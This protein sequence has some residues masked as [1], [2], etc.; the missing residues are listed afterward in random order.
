MASS[1]TTIATTTDSVLTAAEFVTALGRSMIKVANNDGQ[2]GKMTK[3]RLVANLSRLLNEL[4]G[5]INHFEDIQG[6]CHMQGAFTPALYNGGWFLYDAGTL[7]RYCCNDADEPAVTPDVA[8]ASTAVDADVERMAKLLL[9]DVL[10]VV[11]TAAAMAVAATGWADHPEDYRALRIRLQSINSLARILS[12]CLEHADDAESNWYLALLVAHTV[13]TVGEFFRDLFDA[14]SSTAVVHPSTE[15]VLPATTAVAP[16]TPAS[17]AVGGPD[18][19]ARVNAEDHRGLHPAVTTALAST[20]A[21]VVTPVATVATSAT[22]ATPAATA[23][24]SSTTTP[25]AAVAPGATMTVPSTITTHHVPV[26]ATTM[27]GAATA[28]PSAMVAASAAASTAMPTPLTASVLLS[29]TAAATAYTPTRSGF[30][31]QTAHRLPPIA[32]AHDGKDA[33]PDLEVKLSKEEVKRSLLEHPRLATQ[34]PMEFGP[35]CQKM[36]GMS[37]ADLYQSDQE[38]AVCWRQAWQ[39]AGGTQSRSVTSD[40]VAKALG[41]GS[42]TFK[43]IMTRQGPP[44]SSDVITGL[45]N[46]LKTVPARAG[47]EDKELEEARKR[48]LREA[49]APQNGRASLSAAATT[50]AVESASVTSASSQS[51]STASRPV[52]SGQDTKEAEAAALRNINALDIFQGLEHFKPDSKA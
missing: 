11:E 12:L 17:V 29:S 8:G 52:P 32:A 28:S 34:P 47:Q 44:L 43:P 23:P 2:H 40:A 35:L 4:L 51:S 6:T 21:A 1:A 10:P 38:R 49:W 22:T 30:G 3:V 42:S 16:L 5:F 7:L 37:Y 41:S 13:V 18:A 24:V 45:I 36:N 19:E 48:S 9:N 27:T 46:S 14:Q 25:V 15:P 50:T 31:R 20:T 26:I 39:M 33:V